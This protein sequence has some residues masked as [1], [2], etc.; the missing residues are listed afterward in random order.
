MIIR[1]LVI[2]LLALG[3]VT[4]PAHA[5]TITIVEQ[6]SSGWNM[7]G[8]PAGT[9]LSGARALYIYEPGGY[10]RPP[11]PTA[12]AC[13]GVWANFP[14]IMRLPLNGSPPTNGT[15]TCPLGT[16]WNIIGN[17]FLTGARLPAGIT[18]FYWDA[19]GGR[20]DTVSEIP[21]GGAIWIYASGVDSIT[22]RAAPSAP[23][24]VTVTTAP[25][26]S[27]QNLRVGD[28]LALV[29]QGQFPVIL[30]VD[31]RYLILE[32]SSTNGSS[33][34]WRYRAVAPGS[35]QVS[36]SLACIVNGCLAPS[37]LIRINISP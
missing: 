7:T 8:G 31:P 20:Y 36:V 2:A 34:I 1:L 9:D 14:K 35:T 25:S 5:Q 26:P 28:T 12:I 33:T 3:A 37:W 32:G 18:G 16:G 6:L 24:T 15:Q 22:L 29:G 11:A 27:T 10:A 19:A 4:V 23:A 13:R 21:L 30:S 17:P